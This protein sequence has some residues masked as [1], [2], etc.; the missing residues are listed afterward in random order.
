MQGSNLRLLACEAR[1]H[2]PKIGLSTRFYNLLYHL[3][4][5]FLAGSTSL[6]GNQPPKT[7]ARSA[8]FISFS[9]SRWFS[10][11]CCMTVLG[12]LSGL[13]TATSSGSAVLR[14]LL[15]RRFR[16]PAAGA[17]SGCFRVRR[18]FFGMV[19]RL[20]ANLKHH[21]PVVHPLLSRPTARRCRRVWSMSPPAI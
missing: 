19:Q 17:A 4:L 5:P 7:F 10:K 2:C 20:P 3:T 13:A 9:C 1:C 12:A 16:F 18:L 15:T 8:S 14:G 21:E 11:I 6:A